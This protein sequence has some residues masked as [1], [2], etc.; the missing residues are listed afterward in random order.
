MLVSMG[1]TKVV[2]S[3][4][5]YW[6]VSPD[7]SDEMTGLAFSPNGQHLYVAYSIRATV[8]CLIFGERM[9]YHSKREL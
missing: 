3:L 1:E 5:Y 6:R 7:Y 2:G 4:R 8:C 9:A